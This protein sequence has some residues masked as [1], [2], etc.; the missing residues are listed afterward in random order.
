MNEIALNEDQRDCLQELMN[1]SYGAATATIAKLIDRFA[2]LNIPRIIVIK[3][4]ELKTYLKDSLHLEGEQFLASQIVN[5]NISG[6]NIFLMNRESVHNLAL[7]FDIEE[8]DIDEDELKDVILEA[9]N[10]LSTSTVTSLAEQVETKVNFSPPTVEILDNVE[11]LN[12]RF[13][14]EYHHIIIISTELT[15]DDQNIKG[16]MIILSKDESILYLQKALDRI[17]EEF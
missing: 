9:M 13:E 4:S 5:G 14:Q 12:D 15:F 3:P 7:E 2:T 10:I 11:H 6:E 17:L 16:T 8:E 1:V